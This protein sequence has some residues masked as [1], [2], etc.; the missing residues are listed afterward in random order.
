M[1][2]QAQAEFLYHIAPGKE[3]PEGVLLAIRVI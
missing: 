3:E 2:E 1:E